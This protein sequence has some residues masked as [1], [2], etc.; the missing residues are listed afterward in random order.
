MSRNNPDIGY[1]LG[2]RQ[3]LR[4]TGVILLS[5]N[6]LQPE[7][8]ALTDH[9]FTYNLSNGIPNPA[10]LLSEIQKLSALVELAKTPNPNRPS[11]PVFQQI[12]QLSEPDWHIA[13]VANAH[14][15]WET[16]AVWERQR[17]AAGQGQNTDELLKLAHE[18][19]VAQFRAEALIEAGIILRENSQ[20]K[21]ALAQFDQALGI[22]PNH[23]KGLQEKGNCLLQLALQEKA[24]QP[25]YAVRLHYISLLKEY[26]DNPSDLDAS[27]Q[28]RQRGLDQNLA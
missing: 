8:S 12:P 13:R 11:S 17:K 15:F 23:L 6:S 24:G 5:M 27:G 14:S 26:P 25:L 7:L 3:A 22:M 28:C 21:L 20:V 2:I 16:H 4:A 9:R 19:P 10:T 1:L 18:S